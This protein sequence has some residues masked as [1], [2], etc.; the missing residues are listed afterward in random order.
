M[1]IEKINIVSYRCIYCIFRLFTSYLLGYV[2]E[3]MD[4]SFNAFII[5]AEMYYL[6]SKLMLCLYVLRNKACIL[7]ISSDILCDIMSL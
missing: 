7:Y 3:D 2:Q 5:F 4:I 6:L 1:E